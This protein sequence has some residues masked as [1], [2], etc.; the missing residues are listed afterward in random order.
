MSNYLMYDLDFRNLSTIYARVRIKY[1]STQ[2]RLVILTCL[3]LAR[4][5]WNR[6][7]VVIITPGLFADE[8]FQISTVGRHPVHVRSFDRNASVPG[9]TLTPVIEKNIA[10][11][12]TVISIY[13]V[14]IIISSALGSEKRVARRSFY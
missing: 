11:S 5:H 7:V 10:V 1:L 14:N 2:S 6:P 4:G 3:P 9:T 12:S 8:V 13:P